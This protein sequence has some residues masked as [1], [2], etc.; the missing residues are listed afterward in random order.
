VWQVVVGV[1]LLA[2]AGCSEGSASKGLELQDEDY[3]RARESFKTKLTKQGAAPQRAP[4]L[5]PAGD[6]E[7]VQYPSG[8]AKLSAY[9]SP[10]NQGGPKKPAVLFLHGGFALGADDWQSTRPYRDA[11]F[12]V[13]TPS[14][15]GENGQPGSYSMFY[16]EV[17]D[18]LAAAEYFAQHPNVDANRMYL[19][20]HSAGGTLTLLAA[21]A[22]KRFKAAAS[23]SGSPDQIA[24]VQGQ[25]EL[26]PFNRSDVREMQMRSP[27]AYATSFKCPTRLF[28]GSQEWMSFGG[29]SKETAKRAKTKGLDV[30]AVSV[31]GDHFTALAEEMRQSIPFFQQH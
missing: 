1:A 2:A 12:V 15:R 16:D 6:G 25:E 23:F 26:A 10:Q 19:A 14:L 31:P 30:E 7:L 21:L 22:S 28:Y 3:A 17:D 27:I 29:Y 4:Q 9:A 24:F 18:V 8:N 20:G 5:G 11:G 13:M